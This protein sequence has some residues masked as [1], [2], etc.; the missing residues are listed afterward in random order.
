MTRS[1]LQV[2]LGT[3]TSFYF[4]MHGPEDNMAFVAQMWAEALG[5][6]FVFPSFSFD[7]TLVLRIPN[8]ADLMQTFESIKVGV[9]ASAFASASTSVPDFPLFL[10][11][12]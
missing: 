4:C 3:L 8:A 12:P 2:I 10:C 5:A 9:F 7:L 1:D 11:S 6:T